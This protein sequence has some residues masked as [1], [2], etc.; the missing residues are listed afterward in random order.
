MFKLQLAIALPYDI[1][2]MIILLTCFYTRYEFVTG[3]IH[4]LQERYKPTC[5]IRS[6]HT[7]TGTRE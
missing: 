6:I 1:H 4:F 2:T 3:D 7:T 5:K